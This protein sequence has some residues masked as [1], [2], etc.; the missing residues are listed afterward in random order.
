MLH[1]HQ[2]VFQSGLP[3][4]PCPVWLFSRSDMAPVSPPLPNNLLP[5][6]HSLCRVAIVAWRAARMANL[7]RPTRL[8]ID[9]KVWNSLAEEVGCASGSLSWGKSRQHTCYFTFCCTLPLVSIWIIFLF[10][11]KC[12]LN[13]G[14]EV[15]KL[16]KLLFKKLHGKTISILKSSI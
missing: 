12:F 11:T 2:F 16:S 9:W 4:K 8:L 10:R 5:P 1:L 13:I 15:C 14:Y 7:Q 3:V 6:Q